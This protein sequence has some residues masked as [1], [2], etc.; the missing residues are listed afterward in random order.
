M[1]SE[2]SSERKPRVVALGKPEFISDEY[3]E[4]FKNDFDYDVLNASNLLDALEKLPLMLQQNGPI[5]AFIVRMG[6]APYRPFQDIFKLLAPH[7][8]IIAS[9]AAGYDDFNVDWL[10]Q[11]GIW[12]CNSVDAVAEATADMALF[13]I[14]AVVRD[15]YRGE[16]VVRE[17]NWRGPVVPSRD[18]F[19]MTLGIIG[20]GAIGKHLAKRAVALNMRIKYYNRLQLSTEEEATYRATYCSSLHDLLSQSDVVSV[21]CPLN[22]ETENLIS[23]REFSAMRDGA[24]IVNTARGAIID[25][26]ALIEALESGKITRAGL[27]VFLNEPDVND[28][29]RTSDKVVVQPHA[30]GLT[31]VAFQRGE[32]EAFENI[33][34]F[35]K[36]GLPITPVNNPKK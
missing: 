4:A 21:N 6:R 32:R 18:P 35:F 2:I 14:L 29:F 28:Y 17:G 16:R 19:G 12:L 31:D 23:T 22:K 33:K 10:T 20:M 13:L 9:A 11:E 36:T 25:E 34:A 15:T 26:H 30:G 27:D 8:K 5:D 1:A 7:C 3:I 24:F